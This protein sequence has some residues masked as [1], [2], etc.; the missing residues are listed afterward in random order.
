VNL[1]NGWSELLYSNT[2][3]QEDYLVS[4]FQHIVHV[5]SPSGN[6]TLVYPIAMSVV[7][8]HCS[9]VGSNLPR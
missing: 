6:L 1:L 7:L 5:I 4:V 9:W 3:N 2:R 8:V